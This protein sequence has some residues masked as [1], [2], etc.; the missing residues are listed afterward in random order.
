[1]EPLGKQKTVGRPRNE[2]ADEKVLATMARLMETMPVR[3]IS[4]ELLSRESG[5]SKPAIYRRWG[6]KCAVAMDTFMLQVQPEVGYPENLPIKQAVPDHLQA[7]AELMNGPVGKHVAEI[8]GEG[9]SDEHLLEE[10]RNRF[11]NLLQAPARQALEAAKASGDVLLNGDVDLIVDMLYGPIYQRALIGHQPIDAK[12]VDGLKF[13][14]T[15]LLPVQ[16]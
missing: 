9:Q 12:F 16:K 5:V 13:L 2:E 7:I 15:R 11:F 8:I 3:K 1:M 6:N 10:F 14:A 4:I